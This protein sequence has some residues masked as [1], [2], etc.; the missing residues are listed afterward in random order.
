MAEFVKTHEVSAV[1]GAHIEMTSTAGETYPIGA[2][3]QPDEAPLALAP[4]NIAALHAALDQ[5]DGPGQIRFDDFI[6]APMGAVQKAVS[7][8]VRRFTR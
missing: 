3:Y 1:L 7:N 5:L 8:V 2:T 6:V 4:E